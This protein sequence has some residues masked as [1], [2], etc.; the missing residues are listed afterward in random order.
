MRVTGEMYEDRTKIWPGKPGQPDPYP[1]RFETEPVLVLGEEQFVPGEELA[2]DLEH[3]EVVVQRRLVEVELLGD[4][5]ERRLKVA[6]LCERTRCGLE[7]REPLETMLLGAIQPDVSPRRIG[8]H[9][10]LIPVV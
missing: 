6:F 5:G 3:L 10:L 4:V 8:F 7:H 1:W 2:P 9:R